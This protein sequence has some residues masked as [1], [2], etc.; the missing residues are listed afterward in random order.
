MRDRTRCATIQTRRSG[1]VTAG[2]YVRQLQV[3]AAVR[4][5]R[6]LSPRVCLLLH[7]KEL[8]A[9]Y[10]EICRFCLGAQLDFGDRFR[11][12]VRR[13]RMVKFGQLRLSSTRLPAAN[14]R[15]E[16]AA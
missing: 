11:G 9:L 10:D 3:M 13:A 1:V 16:A 12:S 4:A 2:R 7:V 15:N 8:T 5:E 6:R 14:T